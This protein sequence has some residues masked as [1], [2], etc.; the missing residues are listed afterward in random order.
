MSTSIYRAS[1]DFFLD[2]NQVNHPCV[3]LNPSGSYTDINQEYVENILKLETKPNTTHQELQ[4]EFDRIAKEI[5]YNLVLV[6][7]D[8]DD[9]KD[10]PIL[11]CIRELEFYYYNSILHPDPFVHKSEGQ[12]K[13]AEWYF[14]KKGAKYCGGNFKGLDIAFSNGKDIYAGILIRSIQKINQ[15][16]VNTIEQF[17]EG[18]CNCVT[19]IL[20]ETNCDSIDSLVG[21]FTSN[22]I[23]HNSNKIYLFPAK[24]FQDLIPEFKYFNKTEDT[25]LLKGPRVGLTLKRKNDL[26]DKAKYIV[27]PYR[28][29]LTCPGE[30]QKGKINL[31][32]GSYEEHKKPEYLYEHFT[33]HYLNKTGIN[34][35]RSIARNV[36]GGDATMYTNKCLKYYIELDT[37]HNKKM[38]DFTGKTLNA[39]EMCQLY[40]HIKHKKLD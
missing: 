38:D 12:T 36:Y 19:K 35:Y 18:S 4:E 22:D 32:I 20:E 23:S 3:K 29:S 34:V 39:I 15:Q 24:A 21:K 2:P 14:H 30:L 13:F 17:I 27:K 37:D 26:I 31:M 6:M 33:K 5:L 25:I 10:D 11:Y 40:S 16:N 7:H 8:N 9:K 1:R 28:Y